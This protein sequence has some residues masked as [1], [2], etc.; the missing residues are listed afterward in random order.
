MEVSEE[1]AAI[2]ELALVEIALAIVTELVAAP[3]TDAARS[4]APSPAPTCLQ[5]QNH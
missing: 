2:A 1:L 4:I 5:P 3:S